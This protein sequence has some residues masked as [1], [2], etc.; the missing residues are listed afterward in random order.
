MSSFQPESPSQLSAE[1]TGKNRIACRMRLGLLIGLGAFCLIQS[2]IKADDRFE[3]DARPG[4]VG[5][6]FFPDTAHRNLY[7]DVVVPAGDKLYLGSRSSRSVF[8][9]LNA[10]GTVDESFSSPLEGTADI[11]DIVIQP[12]GKLVVAGSFEWLGTGTRQVTRV[13][14]DGSTDS[15]FAGLP[16]SGPVQVLAT[17]QN[18][19]ILVGGNFSKIDDQEIKFLARINSDGT[20]DTSFVPATASNSPNAEVKA[21]ATDGD[22]A[23][24][25]GEF[26]QLNGETVGRI[27]RLNADGS[28]DDSFNI[29]LGTDGDVEGISKEPDGKWMVWGSFTTIAGTPRPGIARLL[30]DGSLDTNFDPGQGAQRMHETSQFEAGSIRGIVREDDGYVLLGDFEFFAGW[31]TSKTARLALDGTVDSRWAGLNTTTFPTGI[32]SDANGEILI[33]GGSMRSPDFSNVRLARL[34]GVDNNVSLPAEKGFVSDFEWED[35]PQG[36]RT[37]LWESVTGSGLNLRWHLDGDPIA[38]NNLWRGSDSP[39]LQIRRIT[40]H[41]AGTYTLRVESEDGSVIEIDRQ[42]IPFETYLAPPPWI[43]PDWV[44]DPVAG[45]ITQVVHLS[46]GSHIVFA[47]GFLKK[48][49]PTGELVPPDEF[50]SGVGFNGDI[51]KI[52]VE[53]DGH[54]MVQGGFSKALDADCSGLVR[55]RPDGHLDRVYSPIPDRIYTALLALGDGRYIAG[56]F[57]PN[58]GAASEAELVLFTSDGSRDESFNSPVSTYQGVTAL[59][60]A[61]NG[62]FYGVRSARFGNNPDL[63]RFNSLGE[64]D[65]SFALEIDGVSTVV[66]DGEGGVIIGR[67]FGVHGSSSRPYLVK[68]TADGIM[69]ESWGGALSYGP[70]GTIEQVVPLPDGGFV[71]RGG[72]STYDSF[73]LPR[74]VRVNSNGILDTSFPLEELTGSRSL[75]NTQIHNVTASE[76]GIYFSTGA[77]FT[78][79]AQS[80]PL[81]EAPIIESIS[82]QQNVTPIDDVTL[83]ANVVGDRPISLQ[84]HLNGEPIPLAV[85]PQLVFPPSDVDRNGSYVLTATNE[86]G[87]TSKSVDVTIEPASQL[88]PIRIWDIPNLQIGNRA[89]ITPRAAGGWWMG[90]L[91][92]SSSRSDTALMAIN[93]DGTMDVETTGNL[94]FRFGSVTAIHTETDGSLLIVGSFDLRDT[95]APTAYIV[96]LNSDGSM[97]DVLWDESHTRLGSSTVESELLPSGNLVVKGSFTTFRGES[98]KNIVVISPSGEAV[99]FTPT[100]GDGI[101]WEYVGGIMSMPDGSLLAWGP[102]NELARIAGP[103]HLLRIDPEGKWDRNYWPPLLSEVRP[104]AATA[105]GDVLIASV[106]DDPFAIVGGLPIKLGR[107]KADGTLDSSFFNREV[108]AHRAL[109]LPDEK[110]LVGAGGS[111]SLLNKSGTLITTGVLSG[112]VY[113]SLLSDRNTAIALGNFTADGDAIGDIAEL[114]LYSDEQSPLRIHS[115]NKST[116]T[117]VEGSEVVLSTTV[118]G[119]QGLQVQWYRDDLPL[120]DQTRDRLIL[121]ALNSSQSGNYHLEGR[122]SSGRAVSQFTH[123]HVIPNGGLPGAADFSWGWASGEADISQLAS[124]ANGDVFITQ[125]VNTPLFARDALG[126]KRTDFIPTERITG[127]PTVLLP[128]SDGGLIVGGDSYVLQ[129]DDQPTNLAKYNADGSLDFTFGALGTEVE[130]IPATG[131]RLLPDGRIL[132]VRIPFSSSSRSQAVYRFSADGKLD[133]EFTGI[134]ASINAIEPANNGASWV[135]GNWQDQEENWPMGLWRLDDQGN[136]DPTFPGRRL[137]LEETVDA[138]GATSDGGVVALFT[139]GYGSQPRRQTIERFNADGS[140]DGTLNLGHFYSSGPYPITAPITD[141]TVDAEDRIIVVGNFDQYDGAMHQNIVRLLPDGSADLSFGHP[142]RWTDFEHDQIPDRV[143]VTNDGAIFIS[144]D[145]MDRFAGRV[146]GHN[147]H[148]LHGGNMAP[149]ASVIQLAQKS[150]WA[151]SGFDQVSLGLPILAPPSAS[152]QWFKDGEEISRTI[153]PRLV[154]PSVGP[155]D[156]G[157]YHAE[158]TLD[159][160]SIASAPTTPPATVFEFTGR[161]SDRMSASRFQGEFATAAKQPDGKILIVSRNGTNTPADGPGMLIRMNPNGSVDDVLPTTFGPL[162]SLSYNP[163]LVYAVAVDTTGRI[164]VGGTFTHVNGQAMPGVARL[165]PDGSLD[166]SWNVGTGPSSTVTT[167]ALSPNENQIVIGGRFTSFNG[168]SVTRFARLNLDGSLDTDFTPDSS[169]S[170]IPLVLVVSTDGKITFGGSDTSGAT[171]PVRRLNSDGSLDSYSVQ[172]TVGK[173]YDLAYAANGDLLIASDGSI[174]NYG[175]TRVSESGVRRYPRHDRQ[176]TGVLSISEAEDGTVFGATTR[177]EFVRFNQNGGTDLAFAAGAAETGTLSTA[178]TLLKTFLIEDQLAVVGN[179]TGVGGIPS[180]G[181]LWLNTSVIPS[182]SWKTTPIKVVIEEGQNLQWSARATSNGSYP[183]YYQWFREDGSGLELGNTTTLAINRVDLSD[184]GTYRVTAS[185]GVDTIE[186][187]V[188]LTVVPAPEPQAGEVRPEFRFIEPAPGSHPYREFLNRSED[189]WWVW[190]RP[191]SILQMRATGEFTSSFDIGEVGEIDGVKEGLNDRLLIWGNFPENQDQIYLIRLDADGTKDEE[192]TA[193]LSSIESLSGAWVDEQGRTIIAVR[194]TP[195]FT[196]AE[197]FYGLVRL[198]PDGTVDPSFQST[199]FTNSLTIL[200]PSAD[201]GWFIGGRFSSITDVPNS[202]LAKLKSNGARELLFNDQFTGTVNYLKELPDTRILVVGNLDT[203]GTGYPNRQIGVLTPTG[204]WDESFDVSNSGLVQIQSARLRP[205]GRIVVLRVVDRVTQLMQ[206]RP[207]GA[208]DPSFPVRNLGKTNGNTVFGEISIEPNGDIL[209]I[210]D[211]TTEHS[212]ID[213][214]SMALIKGTSFAPEI[215]VQPH[216][217]TSTNVGEAVMFGV[218]VLGAPDLD[219]QWRL[220]GS[221]IAGN[222]SAILKIES[223]NA[224][225][226]GTYDVVISNPYGSITSEAL[227]LEIKSPPTFTLEPIGG[228]VLEG[229]PFTF[230]AE[231][232]SELTTTLQWF[233]EEEIIPEATKNSYSLEGVSRTDAGSYTLVATNI[234]G[235]TTSMTA[236][237]IV[238]YAPE[239]ISGP[240]SLTVNRGDAARMEIL[241]VGSPQPTFQWYFNGNAL[242]GE[243]S[244]FLE[245]DPAQGSDAGTYSVVVSNDI[246]SVSS[247]GAR[248]SVNDGPEVLFTPRQRNAIAGDNVTFRVNARGLPPLRY[249]WF[250]DGETIAGA[251]GDTLLINGATTDDVGAYTVKVTDDIDSLTTTPS[252][253]NLVEL[254]ANQ[255]ST[256]PG[257]RLGQPIRLTVKIRYTGTPDTVSLSVLPPAS[258]DGLGWAYLESNDSGANT[259][260]TVQQIDLW[261]WSWTPPSAAGEIELSFLVSAPQGISGDQAFVGTV[262]KTTAGVSESAMAQPDPLLVV[263]AGSYH[264][265]DT[266][267]DF[268]LSLGELLRVIEIYNT[269]RGTARTGRYRMSVQGTDDGVEPDPETASSSPPTFT[270]F[271]NADSDRNAQIGLSELLRVIELYNTRSG[272]TRTGSY[273]ASTNTADGFEPES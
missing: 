96:R 172:L 190:D 147:L 129:I 117:A 193:D 29:G 102:N 226:M 262:S 82:T 51:D 65:E 162:H 159:S 219:I 236:E 233:F 160:V 44:A 114:L 97:A 194:F 232:S 135:A 273:R 73:K 192:F 32:V 2:K 254:L 27:V 268:R 111:F 149:D 11:R 75:A 154:L 269:R 43:K 143:W 157:E 208:L 181:L 4:E 1:F 168:Q 59:T 141:I 215:I 222:H 54:L 239:I 213:R 258:V 205:D 195:E 200:G 256:G 148:R 83:H 218:E 234:V 88:E 35:G 25:G 165:L 201:G 171:S 229:T 49:T 270:R 161:V 93:P 203:R 5:F 3:V 12:D 22:K 98:H 36:R 255:S 134:S 118:S 230:T 46:D 186:F 176:P 55:L 52:I 210:G 212:D 167:I 266:D 196:D 250:K 127:R 231:T 20:L 132:L 123:V 245:R 189:S 39:L 271:H 153:A 110:I 74:I 216:T 163:P 53:P 252:E 202:S 94:P 264:T 34:K 26:T 247:Q 77:F 101:P 187:T 99:S 109:L 152:I 18:G 145:K 24:I 90:R 242:S 40:P 174:V 120:A 80:Q 61:T 240:E 248:L 139:N 224:A 19:K 105:E 60:A 10:D 107:L 183:I 23:V 37:V 16:A 207:D 142:G 50:Y 158:V 62:Q 71:I 177:G 67:N 58:S 91:L 131:G 241:V 188:N 166:P 221:P 197:R 103:S 180:V 185:S 113:D 63:L 81:G 104:L 112:T 259:S 48:L 138:I 244:V 191:K 108:I 45:H 126:Q 164:Y 31:P 198:N 217:M 33:W 100:F 41:T 21:I 173:I 133:T 17:H 257:Y 106:T 261:E 140:K 137:R 260:P 209:L 116:I 125:P 38:D 175:F 150:D 87:A 64:I 122:D 68:V 253:L 66:S 151:T 199:H 246:G 86:F 78:P 42:P 184:E 182:L 8:R 95:S 6:A 124:T 263:P 225:D 170:I 243:T 272:S 92:Y 251:T 156:S 249:Q 76:S 144:S 204:F 89:V 206:L 227:S 130:R 121:S 13:N 237:L 115:T 265:A 119:G 223:P 84:W 128:L 155:A 9:R 57:P 15:S 179:F 85:G 214:D 14:V 220:N 70:N 211:F 7:L 169:L 30:A 56:T 228:T 79:F 47:S 69:D 238:N 178:S 72:F 267:G 28:I 235:S 146:T 136:P